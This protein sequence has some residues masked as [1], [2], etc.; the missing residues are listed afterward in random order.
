[1]TIK[2]NTFYFQYFSIAVCELHC[3]TVNSSHIVFGIQSFIS[4]LFDRYTG[5][6]DNT[7]KTVC[8]L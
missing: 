5:I 1:M 3:L 7:A 2:L 6:Q 4:I 8:P